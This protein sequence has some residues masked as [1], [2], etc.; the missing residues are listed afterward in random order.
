[1]QPASKLRRRLLILAGLIALYTLV[2]FFVA[3]LVV[4]S[5]LEMRL[6]AELGRK[7]TVETVRVNPYAVSLTLEK[8]SIR[9]PDGTS[10]FV[11]WQRLYV[12]ADVWTSIWS[13]WSVSEIDLE[14]FDA[15]VAIRADGAFNFADLLAK[16]LPAAPAATGPTTPAPAAAP[17]A[18][19]A[20]PVHVGRLRVADAR[21]EFADAA[22][23]R[24]FATT[25]GPVTF[26]LTDFRTVSEKGA[27]H[28]FAAVTEAGE[29]F[30]WS[31]ELL[32]NP[33][34]SRGTFSVE[35]I[36]LAKYAPYYPAQ[37]KAE[38]ASGTLS[39]QGRYDVNLAEGQRVLQLADGAVQVRDLKVLEKVDGP[40][41]FEL[42]TLDVAGIAADAVATKA[43]VD[44]V[45]LA[46]GTVR[47]R[48]EKDGALNLLAMLQPDAGPAPAGAA[49]PVPAPPTPP[50]AAAKPDVALG[51]L[52]LKDFRLEIVDLV[53]ARPAQLGLGGVA[54]S[55][56]DVTLADGARMPLQFDATWAPHGTLRVAGS[57]E[58]APVPAAA[59]DI[60]IA[61]FDLLPLNPYLDAAVTAR[62]SSGRVSTQLKIAATSPAGQPPVAK[63]G[64]NFTVEQLG[65]VDGGPGEELAGFRNLALRGLVATNSPELAVS[66]E[67]IVL[68]GSYA[69]AIVNADKSINLAGIVR[70]PA[71]PSETTPGSVAQ[72]PAAPT[73]PAP[74]AAPL[75]KIEIA[76]VTISGGDYRFTDRSLEPHVTM[77]IG[78]FGGTIAGLS[79]ANLAQ[80]KLDLKAVVNGAGPVAIV[81][82]IDPLAAAPSYDLK[83]DFKNV[84][85]V[86]LSPYS[87]KFAGYEL[88]RGKLMLDVK[89]LMEGHKIDA[90]NVI[91]LNQFTF[92]GKV[93]SPDAT[94][95]PVRLGVAL[96]K[97]L[98]GKIVIDVP[99]QGRTDDPSF[100]VGRVVLR[101][102]TNLL[103]KAAVSPFSLLGAAFGGGGEELAFQEFSPGR[104]IL[105]E[106]EKKKLE[107]MV[108]ALNNRPGLNV[109]VQGSFDAQADTYE[110][111]RSKLADAVRRTAWLAR[112]QT[113]SAVPPPDSFTITP[114]EH[115]AALQR[116]YDEKFPPG[117]EFGTPLP[118]PPEAAPPPPPPPTGI[119]RRVVNAVTGQ[120]RSD[121]AAAAEAEKN[122]RDA[123]QAQAAAA[124]ATGLPIEEMTG[125]LAE[126][127]PV[128]A[129]DLRA[130]AQARA[131]RVRDHFIKEGG[132]AAERIFLAKD[133]SESAGQGKGPRVFLS[134]Q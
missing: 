20:R 11:G 60:D 124:A 106:P 129:N 123:E 87:G 8:F 131:Q 80:A 47:V 32:A 42:A 54:F 56:R 1:M 68:D 89:L 13:A 17:A 119:F 92:G 94:G 100:G 3:P 26:T 117:T 107:T 38:I 55:L 114:E 111:K 86:P 7:V 101:V 41:A 104:D 90:A 99:V 12:N 22:A 29:K 134:L 25:V 128:D 52:A 98:D 33:L 105:L 77:A 46:G 18:S 103:T 125:R 34:R 83:V 122:R 59:L 70:P 127:M 4:K 108:K 96:L 9:E 16:H 126:S 58:I 67:E 133:P 57:V 21:L 118:K 112:Q 109:D 27:P 73:P 43:R 91:T 110:L 93:E 2:G 61:G 120:G 78:D 39:L 85:L 35:N 132:I 102:I 88:A 65:L 19:P 15:R 50:A 64:G 113:E 130:L 66:L 81:G 5:Q 63:V 76:R 51:E 53:P 121:P 31:G 44:K 36:V 45:T 48:R 84:D 115:A 71:S 24:P 95:L 6:S 97:D 28:Q 30:A 116:L 23:R 37:V 40:A 49:A 62:L 10:P 69:R 79:S 74:A 75:P 82:Q 72:A 14:G